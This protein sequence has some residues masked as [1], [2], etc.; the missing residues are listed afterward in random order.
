MLD[1]QD[2]FIAVQVDPNDHVSGFIDNLTVLLHLKDQSGRIAG[3]DEPSISRIID[4]M[5]KHSL[6]FRPHSNDRRTN[7]VCLTDYGRNLRG[8]LMAMGQK[9][10]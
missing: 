6:L 9:N 7:L 8:M 5:E 4:I 10:K 1:A 3:K 2:I